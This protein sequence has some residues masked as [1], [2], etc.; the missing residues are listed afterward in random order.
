M[1]TK[2][3]KLI[4]ETNA[5][6]FKEYVVITDLHLGFDLAYP[7]LEISRTIV[8]RALNLRKYG[9]KIIILG[10]FKNKIT[11]LSSKEAK[12][13]NETMEELTS[14]YNEVIIIKGNHD[15]LIDKVI[16]PVE[17]ATIVNSRGIRIN[18]VVFAHGH[19]WPRIYEN[20]SV[21]ML[22]HSHPVYRVKKYPGNP[23]V[24]VFVTYRIKRDLKERLGSWP[25]FIVI[26]AFNQYLPGID[27]L[28]KGLI[29]VFYMYGY[30]EAKSIKI[31]SNDGTELPV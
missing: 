25:L 13:L 9:K 15:A 17:N 29:D 26:P 2:G 24:P 21:V 23:R 11:K 18:D 8:Q 22:G 19:A 3:I 31:Y 10:D 4:P 28:E 7:P 16:N 14:I 5:I 20:T 27:I 6:K 30:V 12:F 1:Q